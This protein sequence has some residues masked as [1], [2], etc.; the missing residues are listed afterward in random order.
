MLDNIKSTTYAGKYCDMPLG[1]Y[2]VRGDNIVL[3]GEINEKDE[4]TSKLI[5]ITPEELT[6]IQTE[7]IGGKV[8]WDFES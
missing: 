4:E 1:L 3:L 5:K 6:Q 8:E 7:I 2:V